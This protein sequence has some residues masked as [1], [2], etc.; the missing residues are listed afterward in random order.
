MTCALLFVDCDCA[1]GREAIQL[2]T[3]EPGKVDV[4]YFLRAGRAGLG[5]GNMQT[6]PS[7]SF[8]FPL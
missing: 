5:T 2:S 4:V 8:K 1:I 3:S 6:H 7:L